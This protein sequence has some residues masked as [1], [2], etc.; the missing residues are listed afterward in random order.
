MFYKNYPLSD[1]IVMD[2]VVFIQFF[3]K[4][5]PRRTI[6]ATACCIAHL[7]RATRFITVMVQQQHQSEF[8]DATTRLCSNNITDLR[9]NKM[10]YASVFF[11]SKMKNENLSD[12]CR[13][14]KTRQLITHVVPP[15]DRLPGP[16]TLSVFL[17]P[18]QN[19]QFNLGGQFTI[20]N[21]NFILLT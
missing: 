3:N 10:E 14:L 17:R 19:I 18:N 5:D 21:I 20:A 7:A 8:A 15:A 1:K 13:D 6:T 4:Y 9:T 16:S 11:F 12:H 2:W